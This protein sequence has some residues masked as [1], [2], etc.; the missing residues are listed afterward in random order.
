MESVAGDLS[1]GLAQN[2]LGLRGEGL[3]S[4]IRG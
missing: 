2:F 3:R 1:S 4:E